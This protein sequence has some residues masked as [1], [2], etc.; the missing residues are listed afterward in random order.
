MAYTF[1]PKCGCNQSQWKAVAKKK[2]EEKVEVAPVDNVILL[3]KMSVIN[4]GTYSCGEKRQ[5]GWIV[6]N[7]SK[8][9][10]NVKGKLVKFAGS[11]DVVLNYDDMIQF[12]MKAGD[13]MFVM[14]QVKAPLIPK[15]YHIFCQLLND[16]NKQRIC[17]VLSMPVVVKSEFGAKKE[18]IIKQ[19][20]EMGFL[21]REKIVVALKNG[22]GI[23]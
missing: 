2:E 17:E 23:C 14:I 10:I 19:I 13:E 15:Q 1:C 4:D 21:D 5:T 9:R 20:G 11:N 7:I 12:D 18:E 3:K 22:I 8:R 16:E 6:K